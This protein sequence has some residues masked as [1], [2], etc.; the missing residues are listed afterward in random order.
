[1]VVRTYRSVLPARSRGRVLLFCAA[2]CSLSLTSCGLF[3][4]RDGLKSGF[5]LPLTVQLRQAPTVATAQV[6]YYDACGQAQTLSFGKPLAE[7][8]ARKSGLVFEK[9]VTD[10]AGAPGVDGYEDV[11]FGMA[12][13]DLAIPRKVT[14]S[15]PA[16]LAIG[17]DFAYT[18]AD[19]RVLVSTKLQSLGRG[20]VDV[21]ESSC[22]VKGLNK[23]L[24]E[25]IS[26]V[27]DG[28]AIELGTTN[29]ILEA[30]GARNAGTAPT[31]GTAPPS[32]IVAPVPVVIPMV[33]T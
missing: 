13:L 3:S 26:R 20:D 32:P 14:K 11:S 31:A 19:G 23:I 24:E 10:G 33:S 28:M 2:L 9:L 5:Y 16:T 27:T 7:A 29:K 25:A 8:I 1:M 12:T 17:L 30:A 6:S 4:S 18:T 15:Y 22:E 21:I